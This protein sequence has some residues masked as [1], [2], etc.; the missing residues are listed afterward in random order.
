MSNIFGNLNQNA[1]SPYVDMET[2][3][4][5]KDYIFSR[6]GK[7]K[8]VFWASED[9]ESDANVADFAEILADYKFQFAELKNLKGKEIWLDADDGDIKIVAKF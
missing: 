9:G 2:N 7:I 6:L 4:K 5:A 3:K 1:Q 8:K